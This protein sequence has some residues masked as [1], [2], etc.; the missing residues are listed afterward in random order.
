MDFDLFLV[1]VASGVAGF[2]KGFIGFG[3]SVIALPTVALGLPPERSVIIISI[4]TLVSNIV[5]L[6]RGHPPGPALRRA[7]P[8]IVPLIA[9]A[10]A[11]AILLPHIDPQRLTV[12]IGVVAVVFSLLSLVKLDI[13]LTPAQERIASPVVGLL[14]GL[15]GG[16]TGVYGPPVA[17][18]FHALR[19]D[20][21]PYVYVLSTIFL[22]GLLAETVTYAALHLYQDDTVLLGL[23][24]CL[25]MFVG[26]Q[27]GIALQQR[28][29]LP[30]FRY[31][32][33][34][35]VL[36]SSLNLI[37]RGL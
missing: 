13:A 33:L 3:F 28:V 21:W 14:C 2:I 22:V 27:L 37:V 6:A 26:V 5:V 1:L 7:V 11:G 35:A 31:A 8:F 12:I 25:P 16:P 17:L 4:P 29:S 24:G 36:L 19:Y 30:F 20:K 10:V 9:G 23:L 32:V 34:L 18:Y 15:L